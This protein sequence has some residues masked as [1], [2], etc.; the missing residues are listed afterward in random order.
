[1]KPKCG[2][3]GNT[4]KLTKTSCCD[5]WIC[6]DEDQYVLFSYARNSCYRNHSRYTLCAYH[7]NEEHD[8]DWKSCKKCK[9]DMP[10]ENY[11]DY[12]TN[13]CNF[14][15]LKNPPKISITCHH[16]GFKSGTVEDFAYQVSDKWYCAK[17]KCQEAAMKR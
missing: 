15:K 5:N 11:V 13:D 9:K 1:M 4:E 3:C 6:D 17:D 7:Y 14:E 8:G 10:I 16:C 2:L 12:G